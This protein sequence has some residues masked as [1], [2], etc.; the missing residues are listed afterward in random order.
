MNR[1]IVLTIIYKEIYNNVKYK[2]LKYEYHL[3][4]YYSNGFLCGNIRF[5][6]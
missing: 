4:K 1:N 5:E 3:F 2:V 6:Q